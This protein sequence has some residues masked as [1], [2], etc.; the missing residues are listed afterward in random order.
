MGQR[1]ALNFQHLHPAFF[2]P[3]GR[4]HQRLCVLALFALLSLGIPAT[5][6]VA[7]I[8]PE[9]RNKLNQIEQMT[10]EAGVSFAA[11]KFVESAAKIDQVQ[12]ELVELL[13]SR[14]PALQRLV[15]P[16][17][18]RVARAALCSSLKA[19]NYRRCLPGMSLPAR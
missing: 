17:Y 10:R 14:D 9:Q 2:H 6:L 1:K 18:K 16:I 15:Q 5:P 19:P 4:V 3:K 7:A 11:E 8:T 13:T 12:K